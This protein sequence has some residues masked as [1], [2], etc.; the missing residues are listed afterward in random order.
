MVEYSLDLQIPEHVWDHPILQE[1][2]KAVIDIMTWPNVSRYCFPVTADADAYHCYSDRTFVLL[3]YVRGV[4]ISIQSIFLTLPTEG[5]GGWRFP[6]P[7]L[8]HYD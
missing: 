8:L 2:S 1:M 3:M 5:A 7:R 6:K 4:F